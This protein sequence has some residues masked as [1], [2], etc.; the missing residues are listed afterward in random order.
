MHSAE[1]ISNESGVEKLRDGSTYFPTLYKRDSKGALQYWKIFVYPDHSVGYYIC[2]QYGKVGG[3]EQETEDAIFEGKNIGKANETSPHEQ[4]VAE[5]RSRWTKQIERKGYVENKEDVDKDLRPGA[6]AMLAHRFD[7][8]PDKIEYPCFIQPKLDG[9]RC[10]AVYDN[11]KVELFSR[12]RKQITGLP[13]I[14]SQLCKLLVGKEGRILLDGELYSDLITLQRRP[15]VSIVLATGDTMLIDEIDLPKLNGY[16][17]MKSTQGYAFIR[18]GTQEERKSVLIH[19]L[20]MDFPESPFHVDHINGNKLDNRRQNLR[21]V[22]VGENLANSKTFNTNSSGY[23]GVSFSKKQQQWH[24]QITHNF[25]KI[26]LGYFGSKEAAASAYDKKAQELFGDC[27][28]LNLCDTNLLTF[29]E[30]TSHIRNETPKDGHEIVE[31]HLYDIVDPT[32]PYDVRKDRLE[33]YY[34]KYIETQPNIKLTRTEVCHQEDVVK[35]F[36]A[37]R[38]EGYEG[39]VL[40]NKESLYVGKRSYDLQKVKEFCDDEFKIVGVE[41]GRGKMKGHAIFVCHTHEGK[42][43]KAKMKGSMDD[44]VEYFQN[45]DKYIGKTITVQFQEYTKDGIPRF[46]VAIRFREDA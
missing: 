35:F 13:H 15:H 10:I 42:E 46:P 14:E 37:F 7:K 27:A 29:E 4:A 2:T 38:A 12:Q 17:P 9:H 31:Y 32:L 33:A 6:E 23:R 45:A 22:T 41:E 11:G 20:L 36:K 21:V 39:A 30:L 25:R 8:Y 26:H 1:L 16:S 40:R 18:P 3:K 24:A 44:L 34:Y 28:S 19:R 43:F 5:A